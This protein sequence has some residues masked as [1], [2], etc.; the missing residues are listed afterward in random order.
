[1]GRGGGL[2]FPRLL[3]S[4]VASLTSVKPV[5]QKYIPA[6]RLEAGPLAPAVAWERCVIHLGWDELLAHTRS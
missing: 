6:E 3:P 5:R 1:M 2:A 4:T